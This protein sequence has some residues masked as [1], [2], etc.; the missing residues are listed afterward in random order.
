M[1]EEMPVKAKSDKSEIPGTI[2]RSEAHAQHI[3]KKGKHPAGPPSA[4]TYFDVV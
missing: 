4:P 2:L 1:E 3:W